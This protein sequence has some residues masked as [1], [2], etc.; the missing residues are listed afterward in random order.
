MQILKSYRYQLEETTSVKVQFRINELKI[1]GVVFTPV[2]HLQAEL[3]L[4]P[5]ETIDD[6][7]K[8]YYGSSGYHD[9]AEI[10]DSD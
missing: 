1:D 4:G 6:L 2:L 9:V 3:L 10:H 5:D 8:C 7:L